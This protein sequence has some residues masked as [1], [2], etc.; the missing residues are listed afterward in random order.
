MPLQLQS[1]GILRPFLAPLR[2]GSGHRV[3][4]YRTPDIT[5]QTAGRFRDEM[6][7]TAELFDDVL[8]SI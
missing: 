8:F 3:R 2:Q 5:Q 7:L 1:L 4:P 6:E